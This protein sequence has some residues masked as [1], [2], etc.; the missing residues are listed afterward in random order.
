V[1]V[2][3]AAFAWVSFFRFISRAISLT[4]SAFSKSSLAFIRSRSANMLPLLF[5][6]FG[7]LVISVPLKPEVNRI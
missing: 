5:A 1:P 3:D 7:R 4:I 6:N 2:N